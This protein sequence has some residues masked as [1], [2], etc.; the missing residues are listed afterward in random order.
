MPQVLQEQEL[1]GHLILHLLQGTLQRRVVAN[2]ISQ[3]QPASNR[4]NL[5]PKRS[6]VTLL[7]DDGPTEQLLT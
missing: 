3:V 4:G 1:R 6:P 7:K 2:L 5:L